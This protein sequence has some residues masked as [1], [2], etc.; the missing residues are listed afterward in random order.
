[1]FDI[2]QLSKS[3]TLEIHKTIPMEQYYEIWKVNWKT[4]TGWGKHHTYKLC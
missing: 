1:M 3:T 4:S 2:V